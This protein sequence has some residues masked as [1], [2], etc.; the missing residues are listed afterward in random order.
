[1]R[2]HH[3]SGSNNVQAHDSYWPKLCSAFILS[4]TKYMEHSYRFLGHE[5]SEVCTFFNVIHMKNVCFF[6]FT[7]T[8]ISLLFLVVTVF[9]QRIISLPNSFKSIAIASTLFALAA[10]D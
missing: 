4:L 8:F 6:K 7:V 9:L 2:F 3:F 10:A 1:M 5:F